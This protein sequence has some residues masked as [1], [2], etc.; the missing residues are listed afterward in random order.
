M[1]GLPIR[2]DF[3]VQAEAMGDRTTPA[4]KAYQRA[5]KEDLGIDPDRPM[6]L[7]MGGGEGVGSLSDIVNE[8][9]TSLTKKGV[10]ATIYVVCGRNEKLKNELNQRDWSKVL[11]GEH[12]R[13]R[14]FQLF[15]RR[16]SKEIQKLLDAGHDVGVVNE[17]S[18]EVVG[19]GFVT[20]V[21]EYMSAADLLVSKAGP[22]TIAESA[23]LGLPIMLTS[24]LPGQEAGNV[25][26][27]LEKGF[28]DYCDD[29]VSIGQEVAI[30]LQNPDLLVSMSK[31]AQEA[32]HPT[33]AADIVLDIGSVT[34]TWK[35]LNGANAE[36]DTAL[37]LS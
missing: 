19:L 14:R 30:W 25:D 34:H 1:T 33:A 11:N 23:S 12:K 31:K 17:G 18:V 7:V 16:R 24:F 26:F 29:P 22:G 27:V 10:N 9:Y 32:G 21:A 4:G 35:A 2:H 3:A 8:M 5:M 28:G 37:I 20:N 6:V 13:K 15:R 36:K